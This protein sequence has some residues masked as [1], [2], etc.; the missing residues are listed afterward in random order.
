LVPKTS[1]HRHSQ[2]LKQEKN[3]QAFGNKREQMI[4]CNHPNKMAEFK[5]DSNEGL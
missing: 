2:N 3:A 4:C 5:V 1:Q